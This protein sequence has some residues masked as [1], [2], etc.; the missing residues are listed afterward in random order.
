MCMACVRTRLG[1]DTSRH[2][3]VTLRPLNLGEPN[4]LTEA[5]LGKRQYQWLDKGVARLLLVAF[6]AL[7]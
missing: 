5:S 6:I 2:F 4:V 1:T 7:R 3:E